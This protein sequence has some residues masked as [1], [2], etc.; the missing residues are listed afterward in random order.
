MLDHQEDTMPT[1]PRHPAPWQAAAD[2]LR[3]PDPTIADGRARL[4]AMSPAGRVAAMRRGELT[5]D[6]LA[7]WSR[8]RPDECPVVNG[9]LEW[10]AL[11]TPELAD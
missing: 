5:L 8:A 2:A 6:Q 1:T 9:E 4:W 10:I 11:T 7:A 3:A